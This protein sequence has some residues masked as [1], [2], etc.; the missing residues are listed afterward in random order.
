MTRHHL[1]ISGLADA[2]S[3]SLPVEDDSR[4]LVEV[5]DRVVAAVQITDDRVD[6]VT[7][8]DL[9]DLAGLLDVAADLE[10]RLAR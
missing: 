4:V 7:D 2:K 3:V 10:R 5:D 8:R 6:V 9:L 1:R